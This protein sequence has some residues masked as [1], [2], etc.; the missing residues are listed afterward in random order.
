MRTT[1]PLLALALALAACDSAGPDGAPDVIAPAAFAVDLDAF[2]DDGARVAAGRNFLTAAG[3]VGVVSTIVG[4]NL[5][6]PERATR[7]ATRVSPVEEDGQFVWD[8]QV[9]VFSNDVQ[10]RLVGDPDGDRVG[11]TLTTEN[12]SDDVEDGPFTYYTAETTL[13][14]REGSWRLFNPDV[15]G[16]IL[17]AEFEIDGTPEI[18]F[19]VPQGRPQAGATVRYETDGDVQTFEF[20]AADGTETLVRWNTETGAG[21]IEAE[22]YDGGARA[23][24]NEDFED[25]ACDEID[26]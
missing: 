13:D 2:P 9:D 17:T 15:D 22:D 18:T 6:L 24:W 5:V 19:A 8:T 11:W 3:R 21:S 20:E 10:I 1:L 4:L 23:C 16:P 25:V 26:V 12:R 7:A 14:G